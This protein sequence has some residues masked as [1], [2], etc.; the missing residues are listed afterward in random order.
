MSRRTVIEV[1]SDLHRELRKIAVLND[2][3]IYV[4]ANAVLEDYLS[5]EERVK[6]LIKRLK[7]VA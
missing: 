2:L 1:R 5:N 4:L 3:R 7:S 6:M